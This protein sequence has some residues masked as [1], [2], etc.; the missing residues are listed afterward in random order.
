MKRFSYNFK[1]G[2]IPKRAT[3]RVAPTQRY[4]MA[5]KKNVQQNDIFDLS[6]QLRTAPCV[7]Q[8]R[9]AV[10]AWRE[11]GYKGATDT[12]IEL[13][14]FWFRTDHL[15][16]NGLPFKFHPAQ[17]EA[18]ETLIY[19]YEVA[20][21]RSRKDLLEKYAFD[22]KDLRLPP[23]DDFARYCTKMA[24]GS[25]KTFVMAM[26]VVWQYANAMKED[27][28]QYAKNFLILAPN[29]IVRD[30]LKTD[31][32][33][34][35][36]FRD[37]PFIPKHITWL[38]EMNY[39]MTGE[40]ERANSDGVLYLTNIQQFYERADKQ[41]SKETDIMTAILGNL[42]PTN[43]HEITDFAERI[44]KRDGLL[45]VLNDEAHHTHDE[46]SEWNRFIRKLHTEKQVLAQVDFS[47]TPRYSKG[48]L[49]AWTV[50]DYPLKQAILDR[51]VKRPVKGI[52][53]I[54]EAKSDLASVRYA[55]FM[56]AGV[57][58]WQE[59]KEKLGAV[60][61]KPLLFVM[62]NDTA[63][64]D[65]IADWLRTQYP[66]DFAGDKTFVIH[67][68]QK[69]EVSKKDLDKAREIAKNV[70][71][72]NSPVNAVVSVLMLRE[73][74]DVKNVTVV[75][76]LRP[77]SAKSNIL[78]EQAIGRGLRLMFRG[79]DYQETVDVIGNKGFINFVED[80]EKLEGL[81]FDTFQVG[82][83]KLKI[84]TIQPQPEKIQH[85]I[86]IPDI[87]PLLM[88]KK[89]LATEIE[90]INVMRFAINPLPLKQKELEETKSFL[91]EGIDI[92][93]KEK[94][95]ERA[96]TLPTVQ[97]A[98]QI[99]S[100]YAKQIMHNLKLPSQFALLAPKVRAFFEKKAFG[101]T[102]DLQDKEV[103]QA[104]QS[105]VA[106]YVVVKEFEKALRPL[107]IEQP[108]PELLSVQKML[109][110]T[111]PFPTSKK[112]FE[113]SKTIF[114]YVDADNDFEY[115]FVKFLEKSP[116]IQHFAKLPM[117]FGFCI[118]YTDTLANLRNY[119]PDFIAV[120]EAGEHYLIE[121]KGRED[122]DVAMKDRAALHW[123]E[124]AS[125]LTQTTWQYVKVL[126]KDFEKLKP[127]NFAELLATIEVP[128]QESFW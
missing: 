65:D 114:N 99:I 113:A 36:N 105:N 38:W 47:A 58:R 100:Y 98:E 110:T 45:M 83:D 91:Y 111:P 66:T 30:R 76:G 12:S 106:S 44:A 84:I 77:F 6:A 97:T 21:V 37:F 81:E 57:G 50:S 96:Y 33:N 1:K 11:Q 87:T 93:T 49:F 59:Y 80:L 26:V 61:K 90:A 72:D 85:D 51:V 18:I 56:T 73:G 70:D 78:P 5:K 24:T 9:Q 71:A 86:G 43:K 35:K 116:D 115:N 7:L 46:E 64:A 88:R 108:L 101:K 102:V 124:T 79:N 2:I 104:M 119:F 41:A 39:Y 75:V 19:V 52:A 4:N 3:T 74:W 117:Q 32:E 15:L 94:L 27:A 125:T 112:V 95:F 54:E 107:L 120:G 89:D 13:L 16:P 92:L 40:P 17:R 67:T 34:G 55:G 31:F 121:T 20:K 122:T 118:Q 127:D 62:M 23:Y 82:K 69:G 123:C 109:S 48:S 29:T 103:I 8:I 126:Q 10:S 53:N 28:T 22:S 128:Q 42:P 25:G 60:G 63:E 14:N 68:D